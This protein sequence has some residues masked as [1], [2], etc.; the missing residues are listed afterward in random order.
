[1]EIKRGMEI[2]KGDNIKVILRGNPKVEGQWLDYDGQR[3]ID[4]ERLSNVT[5]NGS[6]VVESFNYYTVDQS[7][8]DESEGKFYLYLVNY[9]GSTCLADEDAQSKDNKKKRSEI[10]SITMENNLIKGVE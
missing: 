9:D 8:T 7:L 6:G 4:S 3:V 5:M 10:L 2:R 1:M